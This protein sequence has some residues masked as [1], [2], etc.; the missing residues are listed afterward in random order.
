MEI[1]KNKLIIINEDI[2]SYRKNSNLECMCKI[3][4][5]ENLP[6]DIKKIGDSYNWLYGNSNKSHYL[7][8]SNNEM[9]GCLNLFCL[10]NSHKKLLFYLDT[11]EIREDYRRY[12]LGSKLII[13]IINEIRKINKKFYI[14]L[15]VANCIQYKLKFFRKFGF[16]PIK[17]RKTGVGTHCILSYPFDQNSAKHCMKLFEYF[18]WREEKKQFISSDCKFAY[19]PNPTGLYWCE[20]K[21]IYVSGLEKQNCCYYVK[22]K[23]FS[24]KELFLETTEKVFYNND[25]S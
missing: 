22:D 17:L 13:F 24:S 19:N 8:N 4:R 6:S 1:T 18:S 14:F 7:I 15:L 12:K 16:L 5:R 20:Q 23:G 25:L 11:I 21:S 3:Y 2:F 9:I 10:I